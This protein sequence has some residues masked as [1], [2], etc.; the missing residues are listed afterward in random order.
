MA[1]ASQYEP[2]VDARDLLEDLTDETQPMVNYTLDCSKIRREFGIQQL[3]WRNFIDRAVTRYLELYVSGEGVI[4][5]D[6]SG[7]LNVA[8][9]TVSD[10]RTKRLIP[11]GSSLKMLC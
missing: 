10:T 3:P 6:M 2:F 9:L 1:C 5:K 8:V 7:T 11:R 4:E